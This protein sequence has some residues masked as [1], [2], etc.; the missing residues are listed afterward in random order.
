[1][2]T[3]LSFLTIFALI[4]TLSSCSEDEDPVPTA[5][6][7]YNKDAKP[8]FIANCAPCHLTG[9]DNPN[10]WDNYTSAKNKIDVILDRVN[11]NTTAEGFMPN[12]GT[13][14]PAA[15]IATLTQWKTDGLLEN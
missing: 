6:V 5:K 10:K 9:G 2:K 7:T 15:T 8:I 4:F 3:K 1:M 13:K 11:R 12:G 14:L